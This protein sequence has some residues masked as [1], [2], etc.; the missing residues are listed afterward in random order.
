MFKPC[1]AKVWTP[2]FGGA[3]IWWV[4]FLFAD[5]SIG[6][7]RVDR[8]STV[9]IWHCE[10]WMLRSNMQWAGVMISSSGSIRRHELIAL[11]VS[12]SAWRS[13]C[14]DLQFFIRGKLFFKVPIILSYRPHYRWVR[15]GMNFHWNVQERSGSRIC[16]DVSTKFKRFF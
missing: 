5:L 6:F 7:D 4:G 9:D 3:I 1:K 15:G 11:T 13:S 14:T 2:N 8:F 16:L 12:D 10:N